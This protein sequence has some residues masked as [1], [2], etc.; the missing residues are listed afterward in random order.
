MP[1]FLMAHVLIVKGKAIAKASTVAA[2]DNAQKY[3]F[4]RG[5]PALN[6]V[7]CA[8]SGWFWETQPKLAAP[9][10]RRKYL[11]LTGKTVIE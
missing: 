7:L 1:L 3:R 8:M 4:F 2:R 5:G 6:R 9:V 11:F 10:H